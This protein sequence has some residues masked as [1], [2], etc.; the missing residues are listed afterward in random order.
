MKKDASQV[1]HEKNPNTAKEKRG[2]SSQSWQDSQ[3]KLPNSQQKLP[4]LLSEGSV[5]MKYQRT[6][7]WKSSL[8]RTVATIAQ[9]TLLVELEVPPKTQLK[10][11]L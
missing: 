9:G 5:R 6:S 4:K 3:Q 1:D 7:W 2:F 11:S 8:G 10:L